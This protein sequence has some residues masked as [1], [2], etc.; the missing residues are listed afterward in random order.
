MNTVPAASLVA[1]LSKEL[2][3]RLSEKSL[4]C[5]TAESCTGGLI[6]AAITSVPGSSAVY[7]GGVISYSNEAKERLLDVPHSV[8]DSVG[9]VSAETARAMAQGALERFRSDLAVSVTGIAGPGGAV[10]GKEVGLVFFGLATKS[11]KWYT[12]KYVFPG[13]RQAVRTVSVETALQLLIDEANKI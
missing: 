7:P 11:G 8:L 5:S 13:D 6:G 2:V 9:A 10:P 1:E 4:C 12:K 3:E